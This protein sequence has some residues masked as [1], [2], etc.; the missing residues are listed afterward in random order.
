MSADP[1]PK[2]GR[3]EWAGLGV[4]SLSCLLLA[5]DLNVLHLALP[6]ISADLRPSS[7]Q[8]L[9]IVDIYGF[10]IAG[11]LLIMGGLGDRIGRRK[12]LLGGAAAFSAASVLAAYSQSA[13]MLIAARALLGI[14][15]A[16]L[17]PSTLSLL[18]NMF[19]DEGQRTVAI[20]V[21]LNSFLVG[22]LI[23][24]V[25]GGIL[26]ENFWWGS[27]FLLGVPVMVLLLIL[28]P[29][30]L[31]EFRSDDSEP[32]DLL[33]VLLALGAVLPVIY[34]LK[35]IAKDGLSVAPMVLFVLG[36]AIGVLFVRRQRGLTS[37]LLDLSL[38]SNR[39]FTASLTMLTLVTA[40]TSG[41]LL[42]CFQFLQSVKALSPF[43][44]GLMML[45]ATAVSIGASLVVPTVLRKY[46]PTHVAAV[47]MGCAV[48]GF[49][50]LTLVGTSIGL[51]FLVG[52]SVVMY[53]GLAPVQVLGTNLIVGN[54]PPERAG[55]A[56]AMQET[57]AEF[58]MSLGVA[59]LG[60]IGTAVYRGMLESDAPGAVPAGSLETA[61]ESIGAAISEAREISGAAG[62][63]L[64]ETA[65]D[66][67]TNALQVTSAI[68]AGIVAISAV[69]VI[70]LLRH[71][72]AEEQ[73]KTD[74]A[75]IQ[76]DQGP[77]QAS[78]P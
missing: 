66:A 1:A 15:G 65:R 58:G 20:T 57:S 69:V 18:R 39:G 30:V 29:V 48:T 45:P 72:P 70:A 9:W 76:P 54:A 73:D 52:G 74:E 68:S 22:G 3:R 67:F 32:L 46:K 21:W 24:P 43:D 23:G 56:S 27:V 50:A 19:L 42:F 35:E 4:L 6:S 26:V 10:L 5:L 11:F 49:L 7:S 62:T 55:A 33:S 40:A 36:L 71:Q 51:V 12:L 60:S 75:H 61:Q 17:M 63:Q 13:E 14:A 59:L 38:F 25:I 16:T 34:G 64:R 47:G 78:T 31:P 8:L 53:A 28:G 37:P 44:A 41:T 2:A 77:T